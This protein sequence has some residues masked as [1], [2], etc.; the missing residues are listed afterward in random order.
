MIPLYPL[1]FEPIFKPNL[2]GGRQLGQLLGR[3][4][5]DDGPYGEAWVLS[6]Q[7]G[8]L[9]RIAEGPLR[10]Q[11]LR[12]L[13]ADVGERLLGRR[14]TRFPLLLKLIDAR[15]A[16]S[17]QVHPDDHH[18]SL[19]PPGQRGKTEAWVV[20]DAEPG[21]RI[22]AGLQPGIGPAEVR[23]A[24][25]ERRLVE[26]LHWFSPR[27]GDC[28]F[29]PAGTVHALGAGVVVFE[30]QQNSDVTFRLHDW[31]RVDGRTG[32]P[33]PLH[34]EESLACID[35]AVGPRYPVRVEP[36]REP[37]GSREQLVS[38]RH[39][40][41]DRLHG[42]EPFWLGESRKCRVVVGVAGKATLEHAGQ[43]YPIQRGEVVLLPAEVGACR[44]QPDGDVTLLECGLP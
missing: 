38:C 34:V 4:L 25:R 5:P 29:L 11:T 17:V 10:G 9:S 41:L 44:C 15:E 21:S 2:W 3:P 30:V 27:K 28:L 8:S 18:T 32:Q 35:F 23:Q 42:S 36:R 1:R 39:F 19:L 20:L 31:D 16:L 7:D 13:L 22:Y 14:E 43:L 26:C 40:T 12:Q 37:P 33:R 24:L 6:D